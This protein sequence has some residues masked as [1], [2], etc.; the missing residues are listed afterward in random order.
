MYSLMPWFVKWEQAVYKCLLMP[1]ERKKFFAKFSVDALLRANFTAR[2]AG[3][4]NMLQDGVYNADEVRELE[5]M[6]PQ[7]D[8]QGQIYLCNG[9]M[10]PKNLAGAVK[11][12]GAVKGGGADGTTGTA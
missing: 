12:T 7:A 3:Y 9:N 4:H 10:V 1:T 2:M 11:V 5:D 8:G 6:N